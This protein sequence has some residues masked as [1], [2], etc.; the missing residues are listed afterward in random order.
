MSTFLKQI[1][2]LSTQK[3][4]VL[5]AIAEKGWRISC[6]PGRDVIWR[7][8]ESISVYFIL[9][10]E[11]EI[12]QHGAD[13]KEQIIQNLYPGGSFNLV[14]AVNKEIKNPAIVRCRTNC[15]LFVLRKEDFFGC[16][17]QY[18]ELAIA[19]LHDFAKRLAELSAFAGHISLRS[20]SQ[21]LAAFLIAEADLQIQ[22]RNV[23]WTQDD[24][25]RKIGTVRDVV[26]RTL[27]DFE[28]RNLIRRS[29]GRIELID[30]KGLEKLVC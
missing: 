28:T 16:I 7:G 12:L 10:G 23:R 25:G 2:L 14:A 17:E 26:G 13:G 9:K 5:D 24:I 19:V 21:R 30:R 29:R 3:P 18:P 1:K 8:D 4:N 22:G 6:P 11:I 20:V 15:D 27:R